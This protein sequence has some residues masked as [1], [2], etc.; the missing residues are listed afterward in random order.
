MEW[1]SARSSSSRLP[2]ASPTSAIVL[3]SSVESGSSAGRTRA[4]S[5]EARRASTSAAGPTARTSVA[6]GRLAARAKRAGCRLAISLGAI[7][8]TTSSTNVSPTT[9][10][11]NDVTGSQL[12]SAISRAVRIA[13]PTLTTV[14]S[15]RMAASNRR[16]RSSSAITRREADV[17]DSAS[18]SR[19]AGESE[20]SATSE[21]ENR[22]DRLS[23]A[24]SV[25]A[26]AAMAPPLGAAPTTCASRSRPRAA[27]GGSEAR[28]EAGS[29]AGS[30][31]GSRSGPVFVPA[32]TNGRR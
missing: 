19:S 6:M 31:A 11:R 13:A 5:A 3:M 16:G 17:G 2:S 12:K 15:S 27:S 26:W 32:P 25:A 28:L 21:P 22:P 14:L 23:S 4:C 18:T 10:T 9:V 7:S 30:P 1:I 24:T 29:K 20:N 8:L